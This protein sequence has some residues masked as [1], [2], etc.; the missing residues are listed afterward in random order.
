MNTNLNYNY[1]YDS[2]YDNLIHLVGDDDIETANPKKTRPNNKKKGRKSE[3]YPFEVQD[4]KKMINYFKEHNLWTQYLL[5]VFG[6]NMAR[7]VGDTLS[8]TWEH[9]Y[10]PDTGEIRKDLMDIC[11]DKT[12]KLANPHINSACREA[13][14][15]Y[16]EKTGCDPSEN[17]YKNPVFLQLSGTHKGTV[18]TS[19]GYRKSLKKAAK[20]VG[21]TYNVGTHSTRKTFGM[22]NRMIHPDDYNSMEILQTIFNHS[23]TKTTMH[24]IGLT[25]KKVDQYY[26]D[27]GNFFNDYVTGDKEYEEH[28]ESPIV[29]IDIN[30][31]RDIIKTAYESG[32]NNAGNSDPMVHIDAINSVMK[33]VNEAQN[34]I[35]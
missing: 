13:I 2:D 17:N 25:K 14:N 16:I 22:I 11:E 23:D 30:D 33:M 28:L 5:F 3:V 1:K 31:L 18:I 32:L 6:C 21:I 20:A 34:G 9:V 27:M 26:D 10:N 35:R 15:L 19:D 12:D 7:R 29:S 4:I 8:L 24:Y